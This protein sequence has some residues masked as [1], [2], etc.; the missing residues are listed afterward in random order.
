MNPPDFYIE[1]HVDLRNFNT[2]RVAARAQYLAYVHNTAA[3]PRLLADLRFHDLPTIVLGEG[4]NI[5]L[6][7]DFD[8]L[9]IRLQA[10][11]IRILAETDN[12][13]DIRAEAG[14]RWHDLV[15]WSLD[16]GLSGLENLSLIPGTCGAA[17]IQNIGAYGVELADSLQSVEVWDTEIRE[18]R[19]LRHQECA[20]SYRNSCFKQ[21]PG[22]YII[23]ALHLRLSRSATLKLD[24]SGVRDELANM[25]VSIPDARSVSEAIIRLRQ[26][27]LPQP[28]VLPNAGSFFKNPLVAMRLANQLQAQYPGLP[29]WPSSDN[30][31]K[32][33]AAWL[34]EQA[35]FKG[36]RDGDA[37]VAPGH[38]LVMVNHD[39]ASGS[40]ILALA[41]RIQQAVFDKFGVHIEPEPVIV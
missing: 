17:P 40:Q 33:S 30:N 16:Q 21:Q 35:G 18:N 28:E 26:R 3:L 38:A 22:R 1:Q 7:R 6:T 27:K 32:L 34:I 37:G 29:S 31:I 10:D 2:L 8:G 5:L 41:Q 24:Y 4:S 23:T 11:E 15:L 13:V 14:A 39:N 20:F 12:A 9:V 36:F 19:V 25:Q